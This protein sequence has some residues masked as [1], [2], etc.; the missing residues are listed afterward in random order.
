MKRKIVVVGPEAL[1]RVVEGAY[2]AADAVKVTYG[3][4]GRNFASGVRGGPVHISNDGI[5]LLREIEGKDEIADLGVRAVREGSAKVNDEVGDG[6]TGIAILI[7]SILKAIGVD[8]AVGVSISAMMDQIEKEKKHAV[9]ILK[10]LSKEVE[11]EEELIKVAQVSVENPVLA[12]LIGKAQWAVGPGGMVLC[13]EANSVE[14]SVEYIHGIKIDNGYSTSRILNNPEKQSL[15]LVDIH[16]ILTNHIFQNNVNPIVPVL[17]QLAERGALNVLIIARGFDEGAIQT[18]VRNIQKEG[19]INIFPVNSPYVDQNEIMEDLAAVLGAKYIVTDNRNLETMVIGDVGMAS[20]VSYRRHEGLVAGFPEGHNANVD[21]RVKERVERLEKELEAKDISAFQR[22]HLQTR[23]AQLKTGTALIKVGA[24]TEQMRRYK[25]DKVEDAVNAVRAAMQEGVVPGAGLALMKVADELADGA[26][27]KEALRA[28]H[29][30]ILATMGSD[31]KVPEW[32]QDP[33][34]VIRLGI[35]KAC[36]IASSLA[37][38]E[39]AINWEREKPQYVT[40][41]DSRIAADPDED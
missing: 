26:Y 21:N 13:E 35:E 32:V 4:R 12:E 38:T 22:K 23:L 3:P 9:T 8:G 41:I 25:K 37:T 19:A 17:T 5:S 16:V 27:L 39:V 11:T 7:Q 20:K 40:N 30:R 29:L 33:T 2:F 14:D 6:T 1:K 24:E 15:D 28:P 18:C 10:K 34:K 36:E 31:F